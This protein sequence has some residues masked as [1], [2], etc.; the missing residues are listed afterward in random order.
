MS[1]KFLVSKIFNQLRC[2]VSY[3]LS[4]IGIVRVRHLP[5]FVSVEPANICQLH[6]PE[7]P[8]GRGNKEQHAISINKTP[9]NHLMSMD[10]FTLV[11]NQVKSHAHTMQFYF[12]G[13]PLLNP[14]LPLMIARAHEE[15]LFTIVST[16]AQALTREIAYALVKSG[17]NR[18]IVSIDGFTQ[19]SYAT[20]RIG[21]KLQKALDG[22]RYLSES[23]QQLHASICIE[24]QVLRLRSNEH[25]WQWIRHHYRSLGATRLVFKTAQLYDYKHGNPLMTNNLHHSRYRRNDDGTYY[26]YRSW[27]RRHWIN[28][29]CYRLWSGCVIT[30][31]GYVLPCCYDKAKQHI[32]GSLAKQSLSTIWYG[33]KADVFRHAVLQKNKDIAICQEC[34]F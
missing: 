32:L 1:T 13:E 4:L 31:D 8:I 27:F 33:K 7:C 21:G 30:T 10:L 23:R 19:E 14:Q 28:F 12:Q 16:N 3:A 24:L 26:L 18:I 5:I 15:G 22:L 6:C 34:N 25:E 2:W 20:Y 11:L 29:P 17:L 9:A